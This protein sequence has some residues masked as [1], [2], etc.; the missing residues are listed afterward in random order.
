M[1]LFLTILAAILVSAAVIGGV[2]TMSERE[3]QRAAVTRQMMVT[4]TKLDAAVSEYI[5]TAKV[6]PEMK[7][8]VMRNL[9][10]IAQSTSRN[11]ANTKGEVKKMADEVA[12]RAKKAADD[13]R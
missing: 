2:M 13:L 9:D 12:A 11:Y 8:E 1:K 10:E 3:K 7:D 5:D 6:V 4:L